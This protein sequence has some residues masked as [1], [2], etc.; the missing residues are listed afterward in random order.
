[1]NPIQAILLGVLQG[2]GEFLPISSSAHLIL[3]PWLLGWPEHTLAF[4]VALHVGTLVA[5]LVFF[6]SDWIR[7]FRGA[8]GGALRGN[9]FDNKEGR[10]LGLLALATVPG[11]VAGLL[12]EKWADTTLRSPV[13]VATALVA[14]GVVLLLA[15]RRATGEASVSSMSVG[16]ALLIGVSQAFAVIPGVSRSGITISAALFLRYPREEA[17][18][19][20]FLLSTPIILGAAAVKVPHLLRSGDPSGVLLGILAAALVGLLAIGFLLRY[21]RTRTYIPFAVYRFLL[22]A[23][24]FAVA[25]IRSRHLG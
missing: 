16:D 18:R 13:L 12:L 23:V 8:I 1:V 24:V 10:L 11:G 25:F 17:A 20:S 3:V 2:L 7:L 4:D 21:V 19:F 22:A 14:L 5:V 9:P 6:A 15:D